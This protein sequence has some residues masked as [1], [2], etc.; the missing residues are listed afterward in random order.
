M[1]SHRQASARVSEL[2]PRQAHRLDDAAIQI[3]ARADRL[4]AS[5]AG[6][7]QLAAVVVTD[8]ACLV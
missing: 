7:T 8:R 6:L 3:M 5:L 2:L 4:R 1:S